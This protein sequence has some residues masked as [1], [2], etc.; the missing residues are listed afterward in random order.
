MQHRQIILASGSPRR[1]DL[2]KLM[3]LSYEVIP[4]DFDEHL[5]DNRQP[6]EVAKEL[7]LGKALTVAKKYPE[8]IVIGSD[9]VVSLDGKQ[10]GKAIDEANARQMLTELAGKCNVISSSLAVV[11]IAENI[12]IEDVR[13]AYVYFKPF[14]S[15]AVE[16]YLKSGDWKDKAAAYGVQSGADVFVDH[17][18]GRYDT[19]LG[20]PTL[21]LA[22]ILQ[23]FGI[24]AQ[25]AVVALPPT[26][27]LKQV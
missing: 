13:S 14:N 10:F 19:I 9:T 15:A 25:E 12:Q 11:C 24:K 7:G 21:R 18:E 20:L 6:E 5:D 17:A 3:G 1:K 2:M 22:E 27:R 23:S 16:T 8:A 4:S 26:L